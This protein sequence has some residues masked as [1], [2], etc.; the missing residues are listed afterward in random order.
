MGSK[1]YQTLYYSKMTAREP[2]LGFAFANYPSPNFQEA[3]KNDPSVKTH[4]PI[5]GYP[6]CHQW[7]KKIRADLVSASEKAGYFDKHIG[8][9]DVANRVHAYK[10]KHKLSWGSDITPED[11]IAKILLADSRDMQIKSTES[12]ID[13]TNNSVGTMLSRGLVNATQSLKAWTI[14]PLKREVTLQTLPVMHA[15]FYFFLIVFTPV[16][17]ALSGYS[18]R[19]LGSLCGLF[20]ITIFMQ[21]IWHLVGF[22]ER[23]VLDPMGENTTVAAMRNMAVLFYIV[24]PGL[25][26]KLSS[27]FGGDAGAGL[28]GLVSASNQV[29]NESTESS[30]KVVKAGGRLARLGR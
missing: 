28:A 29:T 25:L 14:T 8:R 20:L 27:H 23:S 15:F 10:A 11:Y 4:M 7:W 12:F 5:N 17:L 26:L 16:V 6:T 21:Y 22:V 19:A 2:V 30:I 18:P 3:A 13:P 9:I 1:T 24:A